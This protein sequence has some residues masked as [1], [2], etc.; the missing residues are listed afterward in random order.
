[1]NK[2]QRKVTFVTTPTKNK[3]NINTQST[4]NKKV[5]PVYF[6]SLKT[7]GVQKLLDYVKRVESENSRLRQREQKLNDRLE[8]CK[9]QNR[10]DRQAFDEAITDMATRLFGQETQ[11]KK[12]IAQKNSVFQHISNNL[13]DLQNNLELEKSR[14]EE[15][16]SHKDRIIKRLRKENNV[17]QSQAGDKTY[18]RAKDST[19]LD[20]DTISKDD[21][22]RDSDSND[23]GVPDE[24]CNRTKTSGDAVEPKKVV[25]YLTCYL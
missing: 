19:N 4:P 5:F 15:E 24:D 13:M 11:H 23:S 2:K 3:F 22:G 1:M 17:L 8:K 21:S 9:A 12:I 18:S 7:K 14:I 16:L 10:R 6:S 20:G 25:C